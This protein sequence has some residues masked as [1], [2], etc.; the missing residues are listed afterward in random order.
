MEATLQALGLRADDP[1]TSVWLAQLD[2]PLSPKR[3]T[4]KQYRMVS[5]ADI[6]NVLAPLSEAPEAEAYVR[7]CREVI[8]PA[9]LEHGIY[10]PESG[11]TPPAGQKLAALEY[12]ERLRQRFA[13]LGE[14]EGEDDWD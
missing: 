4:E 3:R 8:L 14:A 7:H 12:R 2:C 9:L 1:A 11:H 13:E 6:C 10:D 5:E